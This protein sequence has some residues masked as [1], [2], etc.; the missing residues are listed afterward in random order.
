MVFDKLKYMEEINMKNETYKQTKV[1][2]V[3]TLL[4][5]VSFLP[6]FGSV[7]GEKNNEFVL[8]IENM[9]YEKINIIVSNPSFDYSVKDNDNDKYTLINLEG[10]AFAIT[11]GHAKLPTIRRMIEIPQGANPNIIIND[12]VWDDASLEEMNLPKK[13]YPVQKPWIKNGKSI[14]TSQDFINFRL[15]NTGLYNTVVISKNANRRPLI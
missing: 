12:I 2:F 5:C 7:Q 9:S 11:E 10:E 6:I 3:L 13:I 14:V 15:P 8:I 1:I 4:I